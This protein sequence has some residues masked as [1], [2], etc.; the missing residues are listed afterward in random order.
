MNIKLV[1]TSLTLLLASQY[2]LANEEPTGR[3]GPPPEAISACEDKSAGDSA[4]FTSRDGDSIT[5]ICKDMRGTLI[6]Q[7]DNMPNKGSRKGSP[8]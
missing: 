3:K 4:E 7:P 6:L 8:S 1:L 5:G 2:S